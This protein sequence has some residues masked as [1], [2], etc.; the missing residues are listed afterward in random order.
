MK[1]CK[2]WDSIPDLC[3]SCIAKEKAKWYDKSCKYCS[4]TIRVNR[5]W[6]K[7]PDMCKPC[8][9]KER[10]KWYE[11]SCE[12]CS[13]KISVNRDWDNPPKICKSCLYRY[14]AK[15][16]SCEQC[17][18]SFKL[19]TKLQIRCHQ[20]GWSLP[21]ICPE[22]KSDALL[23]RGAIGSL[24]DQFPFALE[25]TIEKRGFI[26]TDKVAVVRNKKTREIV[27]EVKMDTQGFF[28]VERIAVATNFKTKE[29]ISKTFESVDGFFFPERT[30][31]TRNH[32]SNEDTHKTKIVEEGFLF[33]KH[34]AETRSTEKDNDTVIRSKEN[35]RGFIFK[36]KYTDTNK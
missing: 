19:T 26:I 31:T 13:S 23:I 7:A 4:T 33:P 21:T 6:D 25:T 16:K 32:K 17:G 29:K 18:H 36:E 22:C 28:F 3:K 5:E 15:D 12:C 34:Y 27:A 10:K 30:A 14:S 35:T 9:E 20:N 11:V 8:L 2:D 24:R 1:V